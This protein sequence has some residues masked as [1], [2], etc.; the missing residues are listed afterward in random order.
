MSF[1]VL[2]YYIK[3][4]VKSCF[5]IKKTR[6]IRE[7]ETDI[8]FIRN[9]TTDDNFSEAYHYVKKARKIEFHEFSY[10]IVILLMFLCYFSKAFYYCGL[11]YLGQLNGNGI[12]Y[13]MF[14]FVLFEGILCFNKRCS[15]FKLVASIIFGAGLIL[16][17]FNQVRRSNNFSSDWIYGY[18]LILLSGLFYSLYAMFLSFFAKRYSD[19][20]DLILVLGFIGL[21][22]LVL[23]PIFLLSLSIFGGEVFEFPGIQQMGIFF[24]EYFLIGIVSEALLSYSLIYLSPKLIGVTLSFTI[25]LT[26]AYRD[27]FYNDGDDKYTN[28]DRYY[29]I[30]SILLFTSALI[31]FY[32]SYGSKKLNSREIRRTIKIFNSNVPS[33]NRRS[34]YRNDL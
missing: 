34:L 17:I 16:I 6:I 33:I 31:V 24:V 30:G 11:D 25:P 23:I 2:L 10:H 19:E 29:I 9:S 3:E 1:L 20:F 28:F 7:R 4:K 14:F 5:L 22:T 13:S 21:Y 15:I 32:E 27:I 18:L 12:S 8:E 26:I